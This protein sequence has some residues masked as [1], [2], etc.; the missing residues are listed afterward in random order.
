MLGQP[1]ETGAKR[2][3]QG[4]ISIKMTYSADEARIVPAVAQGL[5]KA[6]PSINL[7]VTAVAFGTKHLLIVWREGE[8]DR[9]KIITN[10][11]ELLSSLRSRRSSSVTSTIIL[12]KHHLILIGCYGALSVK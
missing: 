6:I 10:F 8:N 4:A 12:C 3:P 11:K 5:Q 9:N 7:K 2:A 1:E